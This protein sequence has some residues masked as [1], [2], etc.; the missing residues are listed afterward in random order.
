TALATFRLVEYSGPLRAF[1]GP[2]NV[3]LIGLIWWCADKL[4]WD[5]TVIDESQDASGEGLLQNVG[6]EKNEVE[7]TVPRSAAAPTAERGPWWQRW[8]ESRRRPHTPGVWV[9]YFSLAALPIF[10]IGNLFLDGTNLASRRY[11][12]QLLAVYVGAALALLVTTSFLGIRRYLRQRRLSMPPEMAASWIGTGV[13]MIVVLLLLCTLLPRRNAEYSVTQLPFF[14]GSPADLWTTEYAAGQDGEDQPERADRTGEHNPPNSSPDEPSAST[15]PPD[16]SSSDGNPSASQEPSAGSGQEASSSQGSGSQGSGSQGSGSQ[17][18]GSQSSGSQSSGSQS[19]GSQSSGSQ[20]SGSQNSAAQQSDDRSESGSGGES[21]SKPPS[22]GSK[23]GGQKSGAGENANGNEKPTADRESDEKSRTS[24]SSSETGN[25]DPE[26]RPG[27]TDRPPS[28]G[29]DRPAASSRL[30]PAKLGGALGGL[31]GQLIKWSYWVVIIGLLAYLGWRH[32]REIVAALANFWQALRELLG[33]FLGGRPA[34]EA[35]E[36][37]LLTESGP[38][39]PAF[40]T[41]ADP[42]VSGMVNRVPPGEVVRYTFAAVEAWGREQGIPRQPEQ[43]PFEYVLTVAHHQAA[44]AK[45]AALLGELYGR[46][47]YGREPVTRPSIDPLRR[48]W[49]HLIR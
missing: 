14:A 39:L 26:T 40:A 23:S 25:G 19:S 4:T 15:H 37:G 44:L 21:S 49:T 13:G 34:A 3:A 42:F 24:S 46:C 30:D 9:I 32:H 35:D 48:L 47:A 5:S 27:R 1:S 29:R 43:T 20:S 12:F 16:A 7:G 6:L 38:S 41:F 22:R 18:S 10:G 31:V 28:A 17:S 8:A 33:S 11:A 45:D 36:A 2:I